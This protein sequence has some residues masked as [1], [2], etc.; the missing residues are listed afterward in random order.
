[1]LTS[2]EVRALIQACLYRA[3]SGIRNWALI[4]LLYRGQLRIAEA[5]ALNPRDLGAKRG[6]VRIMHGNGDKARTVG[7]ND[8]G[9]GDLPLT[10][11]RCDWPTATAALVFL[12]KTNAQEQSP[13]RYKV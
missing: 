11:R 6:T 10:R 9:P 2:D 12:Q 3:P 7:L 8:L 4:V 13:A 5:L 1:M